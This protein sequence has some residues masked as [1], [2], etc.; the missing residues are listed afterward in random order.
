LQEIAD[1]L[2]RPKSAIW[3]EA[4]K[5]RKGRPYDSAYAH[6][7]SYV[8]RKYS[9]AVGRTIAL[10]SDLRS[11]VEK[12]LLDDQ[13]P[14][15]IS[16]RLKRIEKNVSYASASAI[17]RYIRSPYGRKIESHRAKVFKKR[18]RHRPAKPRIVDNRMID[19][20]PSKINKRWGLGH[21]EGD[22]IV[23]GKS[24]TGII[25][26]L[27]DRKVR[28][29]LLER[30]LPVS[31]RNVERALRRMKKRYPEMQ[32]ITFDNDI[33]F[34][35]HK[36]LERV[37]GI[38]IYFCHVHAPYEKPSIE[39]L[40]KDLRRY[41]PKSSDISKYS[42]RFV[43]KLEAKMNRRFMDVLGSL[44]PNEAYAREK[45]KRAQRSAKN[46]RSN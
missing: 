29:N 5:K 40:N 13:S 38:K 45:Q 23:S 11:F 25:L 35:E 39:N 44:T 2:N 16:L 18:R 12:H 4:Q 20:R 31:V 33:L 26:G 34:L 43:Q 46:H 17:R 41:I 42:K 37:L 27:R 3:Y 9:R 24:G 36:R 22:F 10:D 32:T 15:N 28:K 1:T 14:E 19:K 6:H 30:I 21:T 7:I 8:R